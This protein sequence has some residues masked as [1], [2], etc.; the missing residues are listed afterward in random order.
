M[1]PPKELKAFAKVT[2][3]PGETAAVTLRLDA[4]SFAY[5]NPG[6]AYAG[7]LS[8]TQLGFFGAPAVA[9]RGWQVDPGEY[10]LHVGR[11]SDDIAHTLTIEVQADDPQPAQLAGEVAGLV[12]PAEPAAEAVAVDVLR[13]GPVVVAADEVAPAPV[14]PGEDRAGP[15]FGAA[16]AEVAE[17]PDGV[18]R[19]DGVVPSGD[20]HLVV[21]LNGGERA[22][23]TEAVA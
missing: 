13:A 10:T 9:A 2:L 20:Q 14:E 22:P 16:V 3:D 17:V 19:A 4:R 8:P 7:D 18:L 11:A 21:L 15:V 5:W 1:R 23:Q 6:D 12:G